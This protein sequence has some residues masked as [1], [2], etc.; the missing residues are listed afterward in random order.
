MLRALLIAVGLAF[1][2]T[3]ANAADGETSGG[4]RNVQAITDNPVING[5]VRAADSYWT[6]MGLT[7]T[8]PAKTYLY[9]DVDEDAQASAAQGDQMLITRKAMFAASL[10]FLLDFCG[11]IVH[12]RGHNL[13]LTHE[14][15]YPI[16]HWDTDGTR[17]PP[18]EC[19]EWVAQV[20]AWAA[21][22]KANAKGSKLDSRSAAKSLVALAK[23][24]HRARKY[25]IR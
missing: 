4:Q 12:E 10:G 7:I 13:G 3:P 6:R 19:Y 11:T 1:I 16:M 15:P 5:A 25:V 23:A 2:A 8:S 24:L 18:R 17:Q 20:N 14:S 22:I 21:R 9:D